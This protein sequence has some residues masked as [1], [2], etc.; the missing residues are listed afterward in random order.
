MSDEVDGET[1]AAMKLKLVDDVRK[2]IREEMALAFQDRMWLEN[3]SFWN[4]AE[5]V[6][7]NTNPTSGFFRAAVKNTLKDILD[8][9]YG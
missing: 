3:V 4:V 2:L 8:K 7:N 9:S 5:R 1:Q 6:H